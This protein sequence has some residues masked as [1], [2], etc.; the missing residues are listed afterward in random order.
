MAYQYTYGSAPRLSNVER[1]QNRGRPPRLVV[2]Y[3]VLFGEKI[4]H[5]DLDMTKHIGEDF[6]MPTTSHV[7]VTPLQSS[8]SRYHDGIGMEP[9]DGLN[10]ASDERRLSCWSRCSRG[11]H[12]NS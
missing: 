7:G 12:R 3:V 4:P 5:R 10:L 2:L 1:D 11:F 8:D 6:L 9:A